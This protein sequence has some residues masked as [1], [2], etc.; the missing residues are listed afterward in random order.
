MQH[1]RLTAVLT[2]LLL[3]ALI[4]A[5]CSPAA[6]P[7][8]SSTTGADSGGEAEEINLTLVSGYTSTSSFIRVLESTFL[9]EVEARLAE[10]NN[11][12]INWNLGLGGSISKGREVLEGME[13]G[14]GDIGIVHSPF[15]A[16]KIPEFN[17]SYM[18]PFTTVDLPVV[19]KE[20]GDIINSTPEMKAV[21]EKY[22][23]VHLTSWGSIDSYQIVS[24]KPVESLADLEGMKIG[25][26]GP[27]LRWLEAAGAVGVNTTSADM[28]NNLQTGVVDGAIIWTEAATNFKLYEV[29]P[30]FIKADLGAAV[31][32]NVTANKDTWEGLPEEVQTALQEAADIYRDALAV[33]IQ[34]TAA[35]YRNTYIE[36]GATLI[37]IP[38]DVLDEWAAMLPPMAQEWA[39][40]LD[41]NGQPGSEILAS[42]MDAMRNNDQP[43]AREWDKE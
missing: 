19:V 34:T 36:G 28:Y 38:Q 30:Y 40:S 43:V 4:I 14:L 24:T 13:A 37:E 2:A 7:T 3:L 6:A 32:G 9:P 15:H 8:D 12:K 41:A 33:E 42:F 22:N 21:W 20:L 10:T 18:T 5:G 23:Q 26:A 29:A 17:I 27:N 11:Y 39:D 1:K 31:N 16:D 35:D 25:G